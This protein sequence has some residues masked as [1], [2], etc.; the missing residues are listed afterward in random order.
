MGWKVAALYRFVQTGE[1]PRL[2]DDIFALCE[3]EGICGTLL[4]APEGI[5]GTIAGEAA[6]LD[7][8]LEALDKKLGVFEGEVKFSQASAKPFRKLRVRL[9]KEIVTL[10]APEANPAQRAG[11]YVAPG[12]WNRLIS[13]PDVLVIDTRNDYE[14]GI[15][16]FRGARDPKTKTFTEFKDFVREQ[17]D[18]ARDRRIAMYCTGGIRC[19]KASAYLLAHGFEEV[20]HLKGGILKY[21]ETVPAE[22]SLWEGGC[23]VFDQRVALGHGLAEDGHAACFGCRAPLTPEDRAQPSYEPGV[24]CPHC[25]ADLAPGRAQ[26]LRLRHRQFLAETEPSL[27]APDTQAC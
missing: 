11:T 14:T 7:R 27:P 16:M 2:R 8:V 13:E 4:L 24:S 17:L 23:F 15:G 26:A 12:D 22:E 25:I 10:R 18:P 1:L 6:R 19:E 20:L 3:R 9:K 5:N 21:L